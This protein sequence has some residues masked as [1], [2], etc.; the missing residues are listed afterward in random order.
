MA[1]LILL[2]INKII[3]SHYLNAAQGDDTQLR[4]PLSQNMGI[5]STGN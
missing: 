3:S 2:L 5:L 4:R 1:A